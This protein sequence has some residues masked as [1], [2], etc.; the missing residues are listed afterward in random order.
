MHFRT[1]GIVAAA[2][3]S[4][5]L[6]QSRHCNPRAIC[7]L[8]EYAIG[9]SEESATPHTNTIKNIQTAFLNAL[10]PKN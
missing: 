3:M 1:E 2:E 5:E 4:A 7:C 10:P 9:W 6:W 8:W